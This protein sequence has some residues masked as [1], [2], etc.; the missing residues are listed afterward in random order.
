MA[1]RGGLRREEDGDEADDDG[2]DDN[3]CIIILNFKA[4]GYNK[5]DMKYLKES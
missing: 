4:Q 1:V 3:K 5:A 2:G